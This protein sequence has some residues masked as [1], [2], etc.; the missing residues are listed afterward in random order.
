MSIRRHILVLTS[1][2]IVLLVAMAA[3]GG[4]ALQRNLAL[5][6]TLTEEAVPGVLIASDLDAD[7]RQVQLDLLEVVRAPS[8]EV[9]TPQ[10]ERL[11][12]SRTHMDA[13]LQA[14][15]LRS[16][17]TVET[18]LLGQMRDS[19]VQYGQ[20]M[21]ETLALVDRGQRALA[22]AIASAFMFCLPSENRSRS[23]NRI[24]K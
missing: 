24:T 22:E 23:T 11:A 17:S 6:H 2:A 18:G 10:R 4:G 15:A 12:A 5:I 21:D 3:A 8:G 16:R 9:A 7:L 1:I 14:L 19:L 13:L 20:A